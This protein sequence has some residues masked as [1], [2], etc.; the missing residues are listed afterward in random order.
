M[1]KFVAMLLSVLMAISCLSGMIFVSAE[2]ETEDKFAPVNE[3][4]IKMY[5]GD[6]GSAL[7]SFGKGD[8]FGA[9]FTV[10]EGKR[11]TQINFHALATY[12]NNVNTIVF[13][14]YQW[15]TDYQTTVQGE[16]LA[17][18]TKNNQVDNDPYDMIIPTNRSLSGE[19]LFV[20][21]YEDGEKQMTPWMANGGGVENVTYF[22]KG[23][24]CS[25]FCFSITCADALTVT[26]TSYTATFMADGTEVAKVTF[27]EGD[28][29]L[30]NEP[31]VPEK[32]GFYGEWE[33]YTLKNADMTINA[34]Y[35][36]ASQAIPVEIAD[37]AHMTGFSPDHKS[38]FN[39]TNSFS[40]VNM[41]GSIT[42][43]GNWEVDGDIDATVKIQYL[44]MM[45][46]H[47][48][49]YSSNKDLPNKSHKYNVI[50]VKVKAP[51]V[52]LDSTANMT[53]IVGRNTEIY[54]QEV[55]N[56]I[57]CDGNEEYWIFDFTKE[58]KDFQSDVIN[59]ISI[60]WAYSTGTEENLNS[61]FVLCGFQF[62]DTLEEALTA[63]GTELIPEE[64]KAPAT[65]PPVTEAPTQA[66]TDASTNAGTEAVKGGCGSVVGT[67]A[68]VAVLVA[69]AAAVAL[70][71]KDE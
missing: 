41:D 55:A 17:Q 44:N 49:G 26:P 9:R 40:K 33:K 38:Y 27:L 56:V 23:A 12:S 22:G 37:A 45:K 48:T 71:K 3:E 2:D 13:R 28:T 36:D 7:G 6:Q 70:K 68:A 43:T 66:D 16:I 42:F 63:T 35:S 67:T 47:Y 24:P 30:L 20:A 39:Q 29:I 58:A 65:E 62:F 57:K 69:A 15:N 53:V 64:T 34:V 50:A 60:N 10:E 54:G 14:V 4:Q 1:K 46:K 11:L 8:S 5:E 25:P 52:C 61:E 21:T 31:A 18:T 59:S 19:L 51:A 32:E